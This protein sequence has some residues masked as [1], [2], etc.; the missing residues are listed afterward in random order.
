MRKNVLYI[1]AV[2]AMA[3]AVVGCKKSKSPLQGPNDAGFEANFTNGSGAFWYTISSTNNATD[4]ALLESGDG[5]IVTGSNFM[6]TVGTYYARLLSVNA[7]DTNAAAFTR[8]A[9]YQDN[10]HLDRS[11]QMTFDYFFDS[12]FVD[13]GGF[14]IAYILFTTDHTDTL[15]KKKVDRTMTLPIESSNE[16]LYMPNEPTPGRLTIALYTAAGHGYFGSTVTTSATFGID[17]IKVK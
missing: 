10:V 9:I 3:L 16:N 13:S 8:A 14:A 4:T 6:P 17:N 1:L 15:W 12:R 7:H 5:R 11:S 2:W